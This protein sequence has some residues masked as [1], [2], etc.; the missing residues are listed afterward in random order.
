MGDTGLEF[1]FPHDPPDFPARTK[2]AMM[3]SS[4]WSQSCF[5]T[6][7]LISVLMVI[8]AA[9]SLCAIGPQTV[10]AWRFVSGPPP[11]RP[12]STFIVTNTNDSG[13]GSLRQAILDANANAGSDLITFNI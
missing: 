2:G 11:V 10:H 5:R 6:L 12:V 8:G 9:V 7:S 13:P 1:F 3:V 4:P